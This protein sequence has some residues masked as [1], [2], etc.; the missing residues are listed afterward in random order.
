MPRYIAKLTV[1]IICSAIISA[2]YWYDPSI[3]I[4]IL[5][6]MVGSIICDLE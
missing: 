2:V 4:A 6:G 5:G 3:A 1:S